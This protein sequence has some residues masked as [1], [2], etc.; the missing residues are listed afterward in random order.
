MRQLAGGVSQ[1]LVGRVVSM[2]LQ[3][4]S[5]ILI[6]REL[7]PSA[8]GILQF[9]VAIFIY[10]GFVNDL[11]LTILGAREFGPA[12]RESPTRA[13]LLGARMLLT[14]LALLPVGLMAMLGP[15]DQEGRTLAL[16]LAGGFAI[17]AVNLR[18][19]LQSEE[20]FGAIAVAD[21]IGALAQVVAVI[22]LVK[23]PADLAAA[24]L[25]TVLGPAT[26]TVV[27]IAMVRPGR[28]LLPRPAAASL[29]LIGRALPL[30]VALIATALY[31]SV[32]SILIGVFRSPEELGYYAAAYRIVLACLTLAFMTHSAALPLVARLVRED[33]GTLAS[34]LAAISRWL[35]LIAVPLAVGTTMV[36]QPLAT[37]VYGAEYGQAAL[38][39]SLLIWTCVTVG[40]NVPFAVLL[41]ARKQ[42]GAYMKTTLLGAML[43]LAL[44]VVAVPAF[45]M[46]GAAW[47]TL[48]SEVVVM[49]AI[50]WLT[51][52][53]SGSILPQTLRAPALP[54]VIMAMA[55]W[56]VRES[57]VAIPLGVAVFCV[58]AIITG[59]VTRAELR[60]ILTAVTGGRG[61]LSS[62]T[63]GDSRG[64]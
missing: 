8:F 12:H 26:T 39:L 44:N 48:G 5:L 10:V 64:R 33:A 50:L 7:G 30:G 22:L 20:R 35:L 63:H 17:S 19:L 51:R 21:T 54:T 11:G 34:V 43:N 16:V 60:W 24:G 38:P 62:F 55:I 42:D 36:A 9:G 31:Y 4:L 45:G 52:D 14:L 59:A 23:G 27:T 40:T 47:S 15:F 6:G 2:A 61:H 13:N 1:L 37:A 41:L 49:T 3:F 58:S 28:S 32:D 57:L 56:P 18:W 46:T 53:V 25:A 29:R